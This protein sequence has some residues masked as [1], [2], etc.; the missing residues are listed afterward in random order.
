[1][2]GLEKFLIIVFI[3]SNLIKGK[4]FSCE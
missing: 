4:D 1:L 3:D 2:S